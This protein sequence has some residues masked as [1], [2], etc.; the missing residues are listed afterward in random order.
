MTALIVI[1][2]CVAGPSPVYSQEPPAATLDRLLSQ[3]GYTIVK[4]TSNVW[5]IDFNGT[6]SPPFKVVI[7]VGSTPASDIVVF[8]TV[9]EKKNFTAS[10]DAMYKLLKFD[11]E[12]DRVKVG[13]DRDDDISVRIDSKLRI[14]DLPLLKE[15]IE[16]V[17]NSSEE[18]YVGMMPFL[19][20]AR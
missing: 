2:C 5:T 10:V 19:K 8:V 11:Y 15:I 16:Q 20:T 3:S 1:V 17:A 18:V 13:L 7:S 4:K 9:I 6:K 14:T 12:L